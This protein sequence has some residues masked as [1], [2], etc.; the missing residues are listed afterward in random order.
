MAKT[1]ALNS[2]LE[3]LDKIVMIEV[4][5]RKRA[6]LKLNE[7]RK[8]E[9]NR[10]NSVLNTKQNQTLSISQN[11]SLTQ[12]KI[13]KTSESKS[14]LCV[15]IMQTDSIKKTP[16][17]NIIPKRQPNGNKITDV[18]GS[19]KQAEKDPAKRRAN[20]VQ[21]KWIIPNQQIHQMVTTNFSLSRNG[22]EWKVAP[23]NDWGKQ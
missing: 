5:N 20:H 6:P 13:R 18:N 22:L 19:T 11:S 9:S 21:W 17:E 16:Q 12:R 10:L 3:V 1:A 7:S 8:K 2:K 4:A 14:F 23:D 15:L